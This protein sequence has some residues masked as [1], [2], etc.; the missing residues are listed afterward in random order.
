MLQLEKNSC[1]VIPNGK[2]DL[3]YIRFMSRIPQLP[4]ILSLPIGSG[5]D[6]MSNSSLVERR[7]KRDSLVESRKVN[8][9]TTSRSCTSDLTQSAFMSQATTIDLD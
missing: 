5:I 1:R 8:E 4:Q 3:L 2:V 9:P 6:R 7:A